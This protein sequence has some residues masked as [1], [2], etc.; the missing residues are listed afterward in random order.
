MERA[1]PSS[2]FD[3]LIASAEEL[4]EYGFPPRPTDP[5]A[6]AAW[7]ADMSHYGSVSSGAEGLCETE[8]ETETTPEGT[9]ETGE[10]EGE[11][12]KF[13]NLLN[14]AGY[15]AVDRPH[16]SRWVAMEGS[17][18]QPKS[19]PDS[20]RTSDEVS[21]IGLGGYESS[22]LIQTGTGIDSGGRYYAWFE[23]LG[24]KRTISIHQIKR[25]RIHPGDQIHL[26]L[27][28]GQ[29]THRLNFYVAN[30][31]TEK[32]QPLVF[33]NFDGAN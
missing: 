4:E 11:E 7:E 21:W 14:W 24:P 8:L 5:E 33:H 28:Y 20:C 18:T 3:P 6:L 16:P 2:G 23:W 12:A 19:H 13:W 29:S 31:T 25:L 22:P 9:A 27:S 1:T 32:S 17:Y 15:A 10:G 26:Y 30:N